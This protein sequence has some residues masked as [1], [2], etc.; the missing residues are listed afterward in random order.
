MSPESFMEPLLSK[1]MCTA[2]SGDSRKPF[3]TNTLGFPTD[4]LWHSEEEKRPRTPGMT[5]SHFCAC[6]SP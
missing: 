4:I 6:M 2:V 1:R 3:F 5:G